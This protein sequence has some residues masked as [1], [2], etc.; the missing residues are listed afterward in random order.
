M[1]A[2]QNPFRHGPTSQEDSL[3]EMYDLLQQV[4]AEVK[5]TNGRVGSLELWKS[6]IT[7]SLAA[8]EREHAAYERGVRDTLTGGP[9]LTKRQ[10]RFLAGA[11][12][13]GAAAAPQLID[14]V[15]GV[16]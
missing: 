5:R 3:A 2:Q 10:A 8:K 12:V 7:A 14:F 1:P 9:L 6:E 15:T 4:L 11:A 16:L 13:A